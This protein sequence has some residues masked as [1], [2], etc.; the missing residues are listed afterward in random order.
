M[1]LKAISCIEHL[2][3][4]VALQGIEVEGLIEQLYSRSIIKLHSWSSICKVIF[5]IVYH[6]KFLQ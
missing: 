6:H 3:C 5:A 1:N 4:A 2:T